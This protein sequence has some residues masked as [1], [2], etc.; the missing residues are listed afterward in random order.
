MEMKKKLTRVPLI[1][2]AALSLSLF[3]GMAAY[4]SAGSFGYTLPEFQG[5]VTVT[6]GTRSS[7]ASVAWVEV[8]SITDNATAYLWCDAPSVNTRA[9]DSVLVSAGNSYTPAY[10]SKASGNVYLRGCTN[11]WTSPKY[12]SGY[13]NFNG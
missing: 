7:T 10:Y 11:G 12:I 1:L 13:V 3:A 9:T 2:A 5:N 8:Y 6:S 4:A